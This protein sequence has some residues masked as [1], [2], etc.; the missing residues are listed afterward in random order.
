MAVKI[1]HHTL[2]DTGIHKAVVLPA[3]LLTYCVPP[4]LESSLEPHITELTSEAVF[5]TRLLKELLKK[6]IMKDYG[7]F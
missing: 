2:P 5:P 7:F 4:L 3:L 6:E 1:S